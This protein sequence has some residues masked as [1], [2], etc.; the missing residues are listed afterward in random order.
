MTK[1][2]SMYPA[3]TVAERLADQKKYSQERDELIQAYRE[4]TGKLYGPIRLVDYLPEP[5][6]ELVAQA[7]AERAARREARLAELPNFIPSSR[8]S[9]DELSEEALAEVNLAN[10]ALNAARRIAGGSLAV[11]YHANEYGD[12]ALA[13]ASE[14]QW[15][16]DEQ[17]W[18]SA[19]EAFHEVLVKHG[20]REE[21]M[22]CAPSLMEFDP[23]TQVPNRVIDTDTG[24]VSTAA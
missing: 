7:V 13:E 10:R 19:E 17:A 20:M 5:N 15:L 6:A 9:W 23:G 16:A 12:E 1:S 2:T 8:R 22:W 14:Q 21:N 4:R 11:R 3:R 18:L 24:E